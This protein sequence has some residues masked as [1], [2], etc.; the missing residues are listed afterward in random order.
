MD[1]AAQ[2]LRLAALAIGLAAMIGVVFA[3]RDS[4]F[5]T[6]ADHKR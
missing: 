6:T 3:A 1:L 5:E 4:R 2:L